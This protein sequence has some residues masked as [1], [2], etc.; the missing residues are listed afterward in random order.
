MCYELLQD[1]WLKWSRGCEIPLVETTLRGVRVHAALAGKDLTWPAKQ[2]DAIWNFFYKARGGSK[3]STFKA[4][5]IVLAVVID[6]E[7]F[8]HAEEHRNS[9][10]ANV[11]TTNT[12]LVS[13]CSVT[14]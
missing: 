10:D 9:G 7:D 2:R 6:T 14:L 12:G 4:E 11:S 13:D 3:K 8:E 5:E 1:K